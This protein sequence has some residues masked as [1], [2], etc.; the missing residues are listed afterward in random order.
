MAPGNLVA[1]NAENCGNLVALSR[2]RRPAPQN[3]GQHALDYSRGEPTSLCMDVFL[4]KD[5][6]KGSL[7]GHC[8]KTSRDAS[9]GK[10]DAARFFPLSRSDDAA[11]AFAG[12]L[13]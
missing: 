13:L 5:R 12:A 3:D 6:D 10:R 7:L 2:A 4:A 11:V 1:R 8:N 9:I